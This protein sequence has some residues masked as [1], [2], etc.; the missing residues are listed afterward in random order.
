MKKWF[1]YMLVLMLLLPGCAK[2]QEGISETE[3][4]TAAAPVPEVTIPQTTCPVGEN[5]APAF[6]VYDQKGDPLTLEDL[7]GKPVILNFWASWCP[8]CK[9]EMPDF[10]MAY[11]HYGAEFQFVMVNLTDGVSETLDTAGALIS[12]KGYTFPV[13]YDTSM[14]AAYYYGISAVPATYFIA[15]DGTAVAHHV[16]MLGY[17]ELE[18]GMEMLRQYENK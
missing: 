11:D 10:Q 9:T 3:S 18:A 14:E 4:I 13:Y 7:A 12:E 5:Q 2:K 17:E 15:S 8:P 16:G 1:I 6:T